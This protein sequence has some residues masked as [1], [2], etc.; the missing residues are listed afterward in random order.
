VD[1]SLAGVMANG[2]QTLFGANIFQFDEKTHNMHMAQNF[3]WYFVLFVPLMV[4]AIGWW[5]WKTREARAAKRKRAARRRADQG[6]DSSS[7]SD[8]LN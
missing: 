4:L 6:D 8:E 7:D 2:W 1:L 3:W 5:R